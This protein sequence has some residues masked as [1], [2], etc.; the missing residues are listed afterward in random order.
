MTS[1]QSDQ[2]QN[3]TKEHSREVHRIELVSSLVGAI[4]GG[5]GGALVNFVLLREFP[6]VQQIA[7]VSV[8]ATALIADQSRSR[9]IGLSK[10]VDDAPPYVSHIALS[11][12]RDGKPPLWFFD[13]A[14]VNNTNTDLKDIDL[15]VA[16]KNDAIAAAFVGPS[17]KPS[18][19]G[20]SSPSIQNATRSPKLKAILADLPAGQCVYVKLVVQ[21]NS[22]PSISDLGLTIQAQGADFAAVSDAI[23]NGFHLASQ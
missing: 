18:Q 11:D 5:L 22:Q 8:P 10:L 16:A 19:D 17:L 15:S 13:I 9:G 1:T 7:I 21:D 4:A 14:L 6:S 12:H 23:W 3:S 2:P 20:A